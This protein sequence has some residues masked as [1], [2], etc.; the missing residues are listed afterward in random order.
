MLS[1]LLTSVL[2][3]VLS[4]ALDAFNAWRR[5]KALKE[6]GK[7]EA[8]GEAYEEQK[9]SRR[10]LRRVAHRL[11][12]DPDFAKRVRDEFAARG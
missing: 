11:A 4:T 6:L 12:T 3:A 2:K 9:S 1:T 10:V 7:A 5:D 8:I